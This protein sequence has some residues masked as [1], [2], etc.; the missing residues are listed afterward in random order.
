MAPSVKHPA[1]T[2]T[3]VAF[4]I[5]ALRKLALQRDTLRK[6]ALDEESDSFDEERAES[7]SEDIVFIRE[8]L[9]KYGDTKPLVLKSER[10]AKV[11]KD[12]KAK[13]K[14]SKKPATKAKATATK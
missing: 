4:F 6:Y 8:T 13:A 3:E 1:P 2:A 10:K 12:A 14:A 9:A 5:E 11:A 7:I